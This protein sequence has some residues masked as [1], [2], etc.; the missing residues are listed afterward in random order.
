[1]PPL[2]FFRQLAYAVFRGHGR[3]ERPKP[4]SG[5][6]SGPSFLSLAPGRV[7]WRGG[8]GR[9]LG[10]KFGPSV[11][12]SG[13][14]APLNGPAVPWN[15]QPLRG[16]GGLLRGMDGGFRGGEDALRGTG[17]P[18]RRGEPCSSE[19]LVRFSEREPRESGSLTTEVT[20]QERKAAS[21]S[22]PRAPG[23]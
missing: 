8:E 9:I 3:A 11:F 22:R 13:R 15:G 17:G 10:P 21:S 16:A 6:Q 5:G 19:R 12:W 2:P 20:G 4:C 18:L 14:S 23:A 1:A 7:R